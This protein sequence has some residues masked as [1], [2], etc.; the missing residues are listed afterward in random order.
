MKIWK[1]IKNLWILSG[2]LKGGEEILLVDNFSINKKGEIVYKS[3]DL[4]KPKM[5]EIIHITR[6]EEKI[7]NDLIEDK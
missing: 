2:N 7:I 5:A 1:R 3:T 6:T 4:I